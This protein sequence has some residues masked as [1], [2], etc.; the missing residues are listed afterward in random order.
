VE[1]VCELS[2]VGLLGAS[3]LIEESVKGILDDL[4]MDSLLGE[5]EQ[6]I[7][8]KDALVATNPDECTEVQRDA[9]VKTQHFVLGELLAHHS[10]RYQRLV[11]KRVVNNDG[12]CRHRFSHWELRLLMILDEPY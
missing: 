11:I 4:V 8:G 1:I 2:F 3:N 5:D 10:C 7:N 6:R 12:L 9:F